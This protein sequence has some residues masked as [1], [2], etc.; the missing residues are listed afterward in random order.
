M[1]LL[2]EMVHVFLFSYK[3]IKRI[4]EKRKVTTL[5]SYGGCDDGVCHATAP[6]NRKGK[7]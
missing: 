4:P 7:P 1:H 2:A 3:T 5:Q 6:A